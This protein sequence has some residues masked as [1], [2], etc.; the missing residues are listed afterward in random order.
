MPFSFGRA[1]LFVLMCALNA[2][3]CAQHL[4]A[5]E[6]PVPIEV[7]DEL[8]REDVGG[9]VAPLSDE[10]ARTLLVR[11]LE[12]AA[13]ATDADS[14]GSS[15]AAVLTGLRS[16]LSHLGRRTEELRDAAGRWPDT[17]ER[18]I[19]LLT[20]L[21]GPQALWPGVY[22]LVGMIIAGAFAA[23]LFLRLTRGIVM[24]LAEEG[25]GAFAGRFGFLLARLLL[26]CVAVG[27]FVVGGMALSF[28]LFESVNPMR[29]FALTYMSVAAMVFLAWVVARALFAPRAA[30]QRLLPMTDGEARRAT[31]LLLV[32]TIVVSLGF[33][34]G[35]F[36]ELIGAD[37]VTL[38]LLR[39]C[40]VAVFA[41]VLAFYIL[42]LAP[43]PRSANVWFS[44]WRS[45][46]FV[47]LL[48]LV[49]LWM[50]NVVLGLREAALA[51]F[52]S[53]AIVLSMPMVDRLAAGPETDALE[54]E[55]RDV[56]RLVLR[57]TLA[58][59]MATVALVLLI[60]VAGGEVLA[61]FGTPVGAIVGAAVLKALVTVLIASIIWGIA[62]AVIDAAS[63]S[64]RIK[65]EQ[66]ALDDGESDGEGGNMVVG[67][68]ALTLL[69]LLRATVFAVVVAATLMLVASALG[70]NIGPLLAGAGVL[71]L[72]I[73]FGAQALVKDVVSG[74]FFLIDDAFRV[75]E[76]IEI[77]SLR[78][79]V[80]KI[81]VRSM[82]LRHHRGPVQ[83]VP[84][85][86][87]KSITNYNRDWVIYKQE[88]RLPYDIEIDRVRKLIKKLGQEM[89]QN[90][91]YGHF[92]IEPLKSQ[93]VRRIEDSAVI[94][95]TKFMCKPRKQ[96]IL[97]RHVFQ[98][99]Q[100]LFRDND[101]EFAVRR[102][103]VEASG[104]NVP[105]TPDRD[106]SAE[107][108]AAAS[109]GVDPAAGGPAPA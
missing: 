46:S 41:V 97:R 78:G 48:V 36:L 51:A 26:D 22:G 35:G 39:L 73:G 37:D 108:A 90:P 19:L 9:F 68:R 99:V 31:G 17:Y 92:F 2:M 82:Q 101:I 44:R 91:E 88:F 34:S 13:E 6:A 77:E 71:G 42:C 25:T 100:K 63:E 69:P 81:S 29:L 30:A 23:V 3:V 61:W 103:V 16:T 49:A 104:A 55:G 70:I 5:P 65:A 87:I 12:S 86:E 11:Q 1:S 28:V 7:P 4:P 50:F 20:D 95:G 24:R 62:R 66:A 58:A 89:L 21:E 32:S 94:I 106:R 64:E 72:A 67:T 102:V 85:G 84:F 52:A 60:E 80:E 33:F 47:Y 43:A 83:T 38:A 59:L 10:Q 56:Y 27:V 18:M 45:I 105:E 54:Y 76:Y 96:F 14:V 98:N 79:E 75:G 8:A 15:F 109:A 40:N 74:V 53:I 93:G 107:Q 57:L